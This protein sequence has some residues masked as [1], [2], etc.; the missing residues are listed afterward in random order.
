MTAKT[1]IG[2]KCAQLIYVSFGQLCESVIPALLQGFRDFGT[3]TSILVKSSGLTG[4]FALLLIPA[5]FCSGCSGLHFTVNV[6]SSLEFPL[7]SLAKTEIVFMPGF[8]PTSATCHVRVVVP[9]PRLALPLTPVETL[10]QTTSD[11]WLSSVALPVNE[12]D[13]SAVSIC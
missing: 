6:T 11:T 2:Q 3:Y 10:I 1:S 9:P 12:I 4:E 13:E 7:P 5:S 8:S